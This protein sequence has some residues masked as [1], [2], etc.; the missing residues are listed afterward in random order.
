[1]MHDAEERCPRFVVVVKL[2]HGGHSTPQVGKNSRDVQLIQW[3]EQQ[4]AAYSYVC[5]S[6]LAYICIYIKTSLCV[7]WNTVSNFINLIP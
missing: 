6:Y 5:G 1:M 2:I 4:R 7:D 3:K